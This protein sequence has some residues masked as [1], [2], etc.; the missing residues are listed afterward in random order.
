MN[1][2]HRP[3]SEGGIP[4]DLFHNLAY[5][6]HPASDWSG[7]IAAWLVGLAWGFGIPD[8]QQY[9]TP[10]GIAA[11]DNDQTRC[12]SDVAGLTTGQLFKPRYQDITKV[13]V[14]V[15]I[16]DHLIMSRTGT[17]R[18]PLFIG[19]GLSDPTGDGAIVAKDVQE[20]AYTYCHR[21]VPVEFHIYKGL[22][23]IHA[24]LPFLEQA[25]AFLTQR[26][27]NLHF[28]NGC[29]DIGPGNSIAPVPAPAS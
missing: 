13:P 3:V 10:Q 7:H 17:P 20:L 2:Q 14:L 18:A 21:G 12:I 29:S 22:S 19:T 5:I 4:V 11:V 26:F 27:E 8:L 23:H 24:G 16:L 6:D 15:R 25:Q 28:Q 1:Y 9:L